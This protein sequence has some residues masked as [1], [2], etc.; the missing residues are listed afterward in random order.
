MLSKI[1]AV[2][3]ELF[4]HHARLMKRRKDIT[5]YKS[6]GELGSRN[7]RGK[8]IEN[9]LLKNTWVSQRTAMQILPVKK[10]KKRYSCIVIELLTPYE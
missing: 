3:D 8:N 10:R 4:P 6:H 2:I 1:T 9:I 5:L 7:P